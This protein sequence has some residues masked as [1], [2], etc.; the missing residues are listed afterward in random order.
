MFCSWQVW[1]WIN[2]QCIYGKYFLLFYFW[3][4]LC[5]C[6]SFVHMCAWMDVCV[7]FFLLCVFARKEWRIKG[8]WVVWSCD[9]HGPWWP[10]LLTDY[11]GEGEV[12]SFLFYFL[13][14]SLHPSFC[15]DSQQSH[16]SWL[17][18]SLYSVAS[19]TEPRDLNTQTCT[20]TLI[21]YYSPFR[22][23]LFILNFPSGFFDLEIQAHTPALPMQRWVIT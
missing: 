13:L 20:E 2:S 10:Y 12:A 6:D 1:C 18:W 11:P 14:L 3:V 8:L 17:G 21:S 9:C 23:V 19:C 7:F 16:S 5:Y 15:Q 4:N 22:G